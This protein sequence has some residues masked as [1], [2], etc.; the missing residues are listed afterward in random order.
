MNITSWPKDGLCTWHAALSPHQDT[1]LPSDAFQ[2]DEFHLFLLNVREM[3]L[4]DIFS[5]VVSAEVL[6]KHGADSS[7]G[8]LR[9]TGGAV[10]PQVRVLVQVSQLRDKTWHATRMPQNHRDRRRKRRVHRGLSPHTLKNDNYSYDY[11]DFKRFF[12][13][14]P[15]DKMNNAEIAMNNAAERARCAD[16]T[17]WI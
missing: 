16:V 2:S 12:V 11:R 6:F 4:L 1:L 8:A 10:W 17:D 15:S 14:K 9:D 5:A 3:S 7:C 13:N